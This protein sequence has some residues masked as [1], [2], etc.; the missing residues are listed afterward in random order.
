MLQI[1]QNIGVPR[2]YFERF[3]HVNLRGHE[4][5]NQNSVSIIQF[6]DKGPNLSAPS[7]QDPD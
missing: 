3:L 2:D 7:C 6:I 1:L 5:L 4:K